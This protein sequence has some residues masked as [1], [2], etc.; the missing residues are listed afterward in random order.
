LEKRLKMNFKSS[1]SNRHTSRFTI[2]KRNLEER[3]RQIEASLQPLINHMVTPNEEISM[4]LKTGKSKNV[5]NLVEFLSE[6]VTHFT[7]QT[8]SLSDEYPEIKVELNLE[9]NRFKTNGN[10][11]IHAA[12]EF[13]QNPSKLQTRKSLA[14]ASRDL[15]TALARILALVGMIDEHLLMEIV[16]NLKASLVKLKSSRDESDFMQ[17]LNNY[18]QSLKDFISLSDRTVKVN[19]SKRKYLNV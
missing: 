3:I 7:Q 9:I 19:N 12:A 8:N 17:H 16:E 15:L 6:S 5:H 13:A 4:Y 2:D 18:T 10:K 1:A 11:A 14:D